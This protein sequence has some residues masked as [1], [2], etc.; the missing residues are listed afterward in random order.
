MTAEALLEQLRARGVDVWADGDRLRYRAPRG[1]LTEELRRGLAERKWE[2]LALLDGGRAAR[3][4]RVADLRPVPRD[5]DLPLSFIQ[6]RFWLIHQLDPES[7]AYNIRIAVRARGPLDERALGR[8]ID[9][10]VR[11]HEV[12]RT[13]FRSVGG[14][15]V[16]SVLQD[17]HIPLE[18]VD[19]R[20]APLEDRFERSVRE[21]TARTREPFDIARGPLL[22][23]FLWRLGQED[24]LL[25]LVTHHLAADGWSF[26][27]ICR[28]LSALY[29][30]FLAGRPSPLPELPIQ[31]G[32]YAE[33]QRRRAGGPEVQAQ[34]AY[35]QERLAGAQIDRG[36][37]RPRT[38]AT[39]IPSCCP[40]TCPTRSGT[41]AAGTAPPSS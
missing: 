23:A 39:C 8:S 41:W 15:P 34:L 4:A 30:A 24:H 33:W 35:W 37:V 5:H 31:Y 11:R 13:A 17:V 18:V 26:A 20:E 12:L 6:E 1:A 10:L 27:L 29:A 40:L 38:R 22:R 9:E 25:L 19:L 36:A 7:P 3:E 2:L 16:Q 21:A 32:D 28:E 14:G